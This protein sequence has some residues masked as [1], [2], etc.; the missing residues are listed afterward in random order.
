MKNY[1]DQE[2]TNIL[3]KIKGIKSDDDEK[4]ESQKEDSK[5]DGSKTE[6]SNIDNIE[7]QYDEHGRK[8][9]TTTKT[10][11][12]RTVTSSI[13][14]KKKKKDEE[15]TEQAEE[16]EKEEDLP[17]INS[18]SGFKGLGSKKDING[19]K[20]TKTTITRK[21]E[22]STRKSY[23]GR[24]IGTNPEKEIEPDVIETSGDLNSKRD[25]NYQ[26]KGD[27]LL[28]KVTDFKDN[29]DDEKQ[30][31]TQEEL[32]EEEE[33]TVEDLDQKKKKNSIIRTKSKTTSIL[34][35][36]KNSGIGRKSVRF[37]TG[38]IQQETMDVNED[39]I[40]KIPMGS[41]MLTNEQRDMLI[42]VLEEPD[43]EEDDLILSLDPDQVKEVV[44][45]NFTGENAT[46]VVDL[47]DKRSVL[48]K[49]EKRISIYPKNFFA[50]V[51]KK[52]LKNS[53]MSVYPEKFFDNIEKGLMRRDPKRKD[54]RV[55]IYPKDLFELVD[56]EID[57][58]RISV[59][60]QEMFDLFNECEDEDVSPTIR[61][62][63][64][65]IYPGEFFELVD[66]QKDRNVRKRQ[67]TVYPKEL[68]DLAEQEKINGERV[69]VY[70][71]DL[72]NLLGKEAK[73]NRASVYPK[74]LFDLLDSEY[75][76]VIKLTPKQSENLVKKNLNDDHTQ[77]V[78]S[79]DQR[80]DLL[81]K[82]KDHKEK[83]EE[84][85]EK[86][87]L[88]VELEKDQVMDILNQNCMKEGTEIN[89]TKSQMG[90]LKEVRSIRP[91][92]IGNEYYDVLVDQLVNENGDRVE[93]NRVSG[94]Q[95]R[96]VLDQLGPKKMSVIDINQDDKPEVLSETHYDLEQDEIVSRKSRKSVAKLG[97][98]ANT[99]KSRIST[100][101]RKSVVTSKRTSIMGQ[102]YYDAMVNELVD[103]M[104]RRISLDDKSPKEIKNLVKGTGMEKIPVLIEEENAEEGDAMVLKEVDYMPGMDCLIDEKG[105]KTKLN[106]L[107]NNERKSLMKILG[108][109]RGSKISENG[110]LY[111]SK[112][113]KLNEPDNKNKL[114][115]SQA[116]KIRNR[117]KTTF[118]GA[119]NSPPVY[120]SNNKP[121]TMTQRE[122]D[123]ERL[124]QRRS[125]MNNFSN[126]KKKKETDKVKNDILHGKNSG[127]NR[128]SMTNSR[129]NLTNSRKR[130]N[131][132]HP[133]DRK[134]PDRNALISGEELGIL[135]WEEPQS[136]KNKK[137]IQK[138]RM[139]Q[140][141][142][143]NRSGSRDK[144]FTVGN[145]SGNS[146]SKE[147]L[148]RLKDEDFKRRREEQLKREE[149][150]NE[151]KRAEILRKE[152]DRKKQI[153]LDKAKKKKE[154][155][156]RLAQEKKRIEDLRIANE[157][158]RL[159]QLEIAKKKREIEEERIAKHKKK[160]AELRRLSNLRKKQQEEDMRLEQ[161]ALELRLK[162]EKLKKK[163]RAEELRKRNTI[164]NL[165]DKKAKGSPKR[166]TLGP[167][168]P[169]S[170]KNRKKNKTLHVK[171]KKY[172][173]TESEYDDYINDTEE[174]SFN[175]RKTKNGSK[176][177]NK[178][179]TISNLHDR[180]YA[181][182]ENISSGKH[183]VSEGLDLKGG[184]ESPKSED[185]SIRRKREERKRE[186]A[187][188]RELEEE[189]EREK[190]RKR[191]ADLEAK[192]R[193]EEKN[194][195]EYLRSNF[196]Y[197]IKV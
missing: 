36:K 13:S 26:V 127:K 83:E 112:G 76:N 101:T 110:S 15:D 164:R 120:G 28:S 91:T 126:L 50:M 116:R 133:K 163:Q 99:R 114:T 68:F 74:D 63:A 80:K 65:T 44:H 75:S 12:T 152:L 106:D 139:T 146:M 90:D 40:R 19:K 52:R 196:F 1:L 107:S 176:V 128:G 135:E 185:S 173:N 87:G 67:K 37:N 159:Q 121:M 113:V 62:K 35:K 86:T 129:G 98:T 54:G 32:K 156:I 171:D 56:H 10:H 148:R 60:P 188:K 174:E 45:D 187:R 96:S 119:S 9:R 77:I 31:Q 115:E 58:G 172:G 81:E 70:P 155:E 25:S 137:N 142:S 48:N 85:G 72:F 82:L 14:V 94:S 186:L 6:N 111:G 3:D 147:E 166:R 191:L 123:L 150:E 89:L 192:R 33:D 132:M 168:S 161:E 4:E 16:S 189:K 118:P 125:G 100:F 109:R 138:K 144:R 93:L 169:G 79:E 136:P 193:E 61:K 182:G 88:E 197:F 102:A 97:D 103:P 66:K 124:R 30:S 55:S 73:K 78:L 122:A 190:E 157:N 2:M 181:G 184:E 7:D 22:T 108:E 95:R 5:N 34:R 117:K 141:G 47:G 8:K 195:S 180:Y 64:K 11:V 134:S 160:N 59:Y 18:E 158:K 71:R 167:N 17:E 20:R 38:E 130:L 175:R 154:M 178:R 51:E 27:Q 140:W 43:N 131:T 105:R 24:L 23:G 194:N 104:G 39:F 57:E 151:R 29:K 69:S 42:E 53:R 84:T 92:I 165:K 162:E 46:V 170:S 143:P 179:K 41:I 149:E 183:I 49:G 177:K 21:V 145:S 153:E